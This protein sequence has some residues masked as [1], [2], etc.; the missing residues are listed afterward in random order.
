[1][2][3]LCFV[4]DGGSKLHKTF[5]GLLIPESA[6][7]D[8]LHRWLSGRGELSARW[9]VPPEKE[10]KANDLISGRGH[11]SAPD[12]TRP[13]ASLSD[14]LA[15]YKIVLRTI[16]TCVSL[17]VTVTTRRHARR[18]VL[19][20][21]VESLAFEAFVRRL[22]RWAAHHGAM[23]ILVYD[24]EPPPTT[25]ELLPAGQ[26]LPAWKDYN[27]SRPLREVYERARPSLPK[28]AGR[29]AVRDMLLQSSKQSPLI[30]AA[31]FVSFAAYQ[32]IQHI[33]A[34]MEGS[35][36]TPGTV[37]AN[38]VLLGI[39]YR[40]FLSPRWLP[41]DDSGVHWVGYGKD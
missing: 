11:Y 12:T 41:D 20:A 26:R 36:P 33:V 16:G 5:T 31:D 22:A 17:R 32:H 2:Y 18:S 28:I 34:G 39:S 35:P 37:E 27:S 21:D 8:L 15:A 24:N 29:P 19:E 38:R 7:E 4:D 1:M 6:C 30:Q 25:V 9:A 10:M 13:L 23:V 40:E 14:R 3:Y